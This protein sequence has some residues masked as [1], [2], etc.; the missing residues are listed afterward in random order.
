[1]RVGNRLGRAVVLVENGTVDVAK[2]SHDHFSSSIDDII[3]QMD[4]LRDWW[5]SAAIGAPVDAFDTS[6]FR[7][8]GPVVNAP[9]QVFAIG[10]NYHAHAGEM[11]LVLPDVPLVFSKFASCLAGPFASIPRV[12]DMTDWEAELV[13][14]IGRR[15]RNIAPEDALDYVA[16]YCVGQDVSDRDLQMK[17]ANAQ[18]SMG[19][20]YQNFGPIGPWVTSADEIANPNNLDI[21]CRVN[22]ELFQDSNTSNMIFSVRD[23]V[24]YV[25]SICELRPG[26]VFFTGSPDGTGKGQQPPRFLRTGD[27]VSTTIEGLGT[28]VNHVVDTL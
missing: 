6:M 12:S 5:H 4:D 3:A 21:Q 25:S 16:G 15:G 13:V 24:A 20:S 8:L 7:E 27:E 1:M 18:F 22:G 23:V 19:K 11:G 14:V 26:D 28:I 2:A 10:L 17:G 9:S